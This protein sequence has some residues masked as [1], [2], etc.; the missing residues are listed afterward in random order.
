MTDETPAPDPA[1]R[2]QAEEVSRTSSDET[3][4]KPGSQFA[5]LLGNVTEGEKL[6]KGAVWSALGGTWG[7]VEST[8]PA[9]VFIVVQTFVRSVPVSVVATGS[10][11][12]LLA[13]IRALAVKGTFQSVVSGAIGASIGL[14][15]ALSSNDANNVFVP[16]FVINAAYLVILGASAIV[17]HPV[18]G[19]LIGVFRGD[20]SG[21]R[22]E[23][24]LRRANVLATLVFAAP[25]LIRLSVLFPMWLAKVDVAVL[26]S[27]KLALGL[28]LT[29]AALIGCYLILRP[30]YV[31]RDEAAVE[32]AETLD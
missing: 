12:V 27:V 2:S 6:D 28:P 18:S 30:A 26:G 16:G 9:V 31:V 4:A 29:G 15:F 1:A 10:V 13:L 23:P 32:E 14:I 17:G 3:A 7:V 22:S 20:M 8:L 25:S 21:W 19:Y 24:I 11:V 5:Q